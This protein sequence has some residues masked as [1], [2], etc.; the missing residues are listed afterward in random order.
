MLTW[1]GTRYHSTV[2]FYS[3][4]VL[5][6][7]LAKQVLTESIPTKGTKMIFVQYLNI[8]TEDTYTA[9]LAIKG[10]QLLEAKSI[11]WRLT[12]PTSTDFS[13]IDPC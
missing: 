12:C 13:Q 8:H 11:A 4:V 2:K 6:A 1:T 5:V 7:S 9:I 3:S 10:V